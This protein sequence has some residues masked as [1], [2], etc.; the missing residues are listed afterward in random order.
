ME[1]RRSHRAIAEEAVTIAEVG[2]LL[3]RVARTV[4]VLGAPPQD[5][6]LRPYPSG[7]AI[8]ELEFYLAVG[9]CDGLAVGFYH[10]DGHAH[11]L[12]RLT[13]GTEVAASIVRDAGHAW[14]QPNR[15]PQ[16]VVVISARLPRLAWKYQGFAYRISAINAGVAIQSLYLVATVMGLACAAIGSG[17]PARF[18]AATGLDPLTETSIGEFGF[19][20]AAELAGQPYRSGRR[21]GV[22]K[23]C[24]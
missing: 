17:D 4:R 7:G 3:H 22:L 18:A 16:V 11:A 19:G 1:R 24:R 9:A 2:T 12:V 23:M 20:R 6:L 8:H 5:G 13:A 14:G 21:R 15:P 10:Y